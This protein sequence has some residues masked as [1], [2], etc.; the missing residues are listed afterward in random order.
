[1]SET[2]NNELARILGRIEGK[3]EEQTNATRRV[4][5]AV[6]AL[7]TKLSQRLDDHEHR[8]RQ[9]EVT[10]PTELAKA[11]RGHETRLQELEK[12]A[13]RTGI[14]AGVGSGVGMTVFTAWARAKLGL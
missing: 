6:T 5:V 12:N 1:M 11:I 8:L 14:I 3:L 10:N 13:V 7:E 9:L 2:T 4:E